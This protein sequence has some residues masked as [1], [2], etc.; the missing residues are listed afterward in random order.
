MIVKKIN[1]DQCKPL[2]HRVLWPHI[3]LQEDC[4]IDIDTRKD[5]I[6]LGAFQDDEIISICSLFQNKNPDLDSSKKQYQL[7]AMAT[8]LESRGLNAGR[9]VVEEAIKVLHRQGT[10]ILW[11]HAR[12]VALGFYAKLGFKV[13]GDFYEVPKIGPHKLM[14][15]EL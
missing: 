6:H 7:R 9:A 1:P 13:K 12:E 11:C 15:Y 4:N 3:E 5:A 2:R 14:Y 10:E 8:D